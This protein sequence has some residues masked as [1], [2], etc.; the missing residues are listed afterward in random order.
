MNDGRKGIKMG[1][2]AVLPDKDKLIRKIKIAIRVAPDTD[3]EYPEGARDDMYHHYIEDERHPHVDDRWYPTADPIT[4]KITLTSGGLTVS[5]FK[6]KKTLTELLKRVEKMPE[7]MVTKEEIP[8]GYT[9]RRGANPNRQVVGELIKGIP[10]GI[11]TDGLM[12]CKGTPP[13]KV[14]W[15]EKTY[16]VDMEDLV[17]SILNANTEPAELSYYVVMDGLDIGV[18]SEPIIQL[19]SVNDNP[20]IKKDPPYV[21]FKSSYGFAI[22]DQ[23]RHNVIKKRYPNAEYGMSVSGQLVAYDYGG[24]SEEDGGHREPVA[25][26]MCH[27]AKRDDEEVTSKPY[28]YD[29][30]V[31]LGLVG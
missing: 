28:G 10:E 2:I 26:I 8:I 25:S 29:M 5:V 9:I 16:S 20:K 24:L 7:T 30:A 11:F 4:L 15:N 22:Y 19:T 27:R 23:Y 6:T 12:L 18:T 14:V 31:D 3:I 17:S 13:G 1:K 21:V